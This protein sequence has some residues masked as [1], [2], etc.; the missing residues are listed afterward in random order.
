MNIAKISY[1][2]NFFLCIFIYK[3][4]N[5]FDIQL[6]FLSLQ[7]MKDQTVNK[8]FDYIFDNKAFDSPYICSLGMK[9]GYQ[10]DNLHMIH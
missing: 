9:F 2:S 4:I 7:N 6:V 3:H 1:L 10:V 5:V 8:A